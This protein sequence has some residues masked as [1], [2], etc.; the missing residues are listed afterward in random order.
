MKT[1]K[2]SIILLVCMAAALTVSAQNVTFCSSEFEEGVKAHL[3]LDE[4][5]VVTQ[6]QTDTITDIDLSGFGIK[7]IRDVVYLPN[8]QNLDLSYNEIRDV[9]PLLPLDSL[10]YVDLRGNQLEDINLLAYSCSDSLVISVAY[11]Y[12]TDFS[13]LLL[14]SSCHI[15]VSGMFAQKV[16]NASY[17]DVYQFYADIKEGIPSINYRGYSNMVNG[18]LLECGST[19]VA[20]EMTGNFNTVNI[21][22]N[23]S[24]TTMATLSDGEKGDT[25]WVVPPKEYEVAMGQT[26]TMETGLP[27]NYTIRFANAIH[28]TVVIDQ[29][30]LVY[31]ASNMEENDTLSFSYYERDVLRGF[32][33]YY[34]GKPLWKL[35]D[36]NADGDID[37]MDVVMMVN[38]IMGNTSP[39]FVFKAADHTADGIVDVIDLVNEVRMIMDNSAFGANTGSFDKTSDGLSLRP[40]PDGVIDLDISGSDRYVATQFIVTLSEGQILAGVTADDHHTVNYERIADDRYAVVCYSNSNEVFATNESILSLYVA[41]SG[42]VAV[43]NAMFVNTNDERVGCQNSQSGYTDGMGSLVLDPSH[44]TDIYSTSGILVRKNATTT[45]GL[46]SGVYIVNGKKGVVR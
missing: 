22:D 17:M 38:H 2:H 8:V 13:R 23:L 6:Q 14:P 41:G 19:Q 4:N 11:N 46:Q 43:E 36:V 26:V 27:D 1:V 21:T 34:L 28:G 24:S 20:A 9:A 35:G 25:T 7:D 29:T 10:H 3:G 44:P 31:T 30:N 45:Q 5:S 18:V 32:S 39:R 15:S 12:I 42:N 37:V 16:K 40:C 33:Q